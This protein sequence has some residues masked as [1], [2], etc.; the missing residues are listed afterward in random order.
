[1]VKQNTFV[2]EDLAILTPETRVRLFDAV[3]ETTIK[4]AMS[5]VSSRVKSMLLTH[6]DDEQREQWYR[7]I[8]TSDSELDE[9]RAAQLK[10]VSVLREM[11]QRNEVELK[12]F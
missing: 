9:V 8:G 3:D 7:D 10:V 12:D 2:F 6:L 5:I 11:D 4:K 1:M